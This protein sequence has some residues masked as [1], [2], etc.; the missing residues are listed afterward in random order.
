MTT[1]EYTAIS[2]RDAFL[3]FVAGLTLAGAL[4]VVSLALSEDSALSPSGLDDETPV[5]AAGDWR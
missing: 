5:S 2:A 4:I 1:R 3:G